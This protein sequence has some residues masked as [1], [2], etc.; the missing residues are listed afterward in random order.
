MHNLSPCIF[1]ISR[2]LNYAHSPTNKQFSS[3]NVFVVFGDWRVILVITFIDSLTLKPIALIPKV[4][5]ANIALATV[6]KA[7]SKGAAYISII[8]TFR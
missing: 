8:Q 1:R 3:R 2:S 5:S 7:L 4:A 6:R